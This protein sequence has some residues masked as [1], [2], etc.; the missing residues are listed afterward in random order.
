MLFINN[1]PA[2]VCNFCDEAYFSADVLKKIE[3]EFVQISSHQKS[4]TSFINV[5]VEEFAEL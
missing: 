4:A 5:P 3:N 2:E 1:V